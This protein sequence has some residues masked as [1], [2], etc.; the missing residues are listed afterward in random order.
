[1]VIRLPSRQLPVLYV[2]D[3]AVVG[4]SLAGIAAAL[5]WQRAGFHTVLIEPRTYLGR[6]I[7]ATFRPWVTLDPSSRLW[8]GLLERMGMTPQAAEIALPIDA[9]KRTLEDLLLEAGVALLYASLPVTVLGGTQ[10]I[11]GVVIANKSGR[12]VVAA[13]TV[14]D[15][16]ETA[17][18]ARL[19]GGA[20]APLPAAAPYE[21]TLEFDRVAPLAGDVLCVPADLGPVGD[22]VTLHH[23]YRGAEHLFVTFALDLPAADGPACAMRREILARERSL[24][25]AAHLIGAVPA[26]HD[27]VL[28]FASFEL[29]G[30]HTGRLDG[31]S[32]DPF[33]GPLP[34]LW[35]LN[36]AA[37]VPDPAA[38]RDPARAAA[39]GEL[40]ATRIVPRRLPGERADA[41]RPLPSDPAPLEIS[42]LAGSPPGWP[43]A[44]R[45]VPAQEVPVWDQVEVLVVGGGTSGATAAS[46]AA[47]EGARTML[48]EM[49]PGLGGTGT[50]GG[51]HSYWYGRHVGFSARVQALTDAVHQSLGHTKSTWNIEAKMFAL[52]QDA[53]RAGVCL[54]WEAIA[55]AAVKE[56]QRVRG[57][58]AA[59]RWGPVA[60]LGEVVIDATG[61]GDVAAF[62]G[63]DFVYGAE[64]DHTTMWYS[65]AQFSTPGRTRN[66]FTSSVD[67]GNILDYTRAILAGRRRG[68]DIHDHGVYP[69]PRESRHI[70]GEVVLTHTDQLRM[71][72]WRDV[73]NV[74]YSNHDVKGP[75]T[76]PWVRMGLIPPNLEIEVPYL[77]LIP[78]SLDGLIVTGKAI[79]ATHDAL[80]AIR[81]QADLENLGGVAALAALQALRRGVAP[82]DLDVATLQQRLVKED[83]LTP[84]ILACCV[85]LPVYRDE[86]LSDL[87]AAIDGSQPLWAYSDMEMGEI[88]QG[89]LPL[90]E[91][92]CAG[93]RIVPYLAEALAGARG[94]RRI[95]LAQALAFYGSPAA[96]PVLIEEIMARLQGD[97]LPV[98]DN[99]IRHANYPP[100][101]GAMPDVVYLLYSLGMTRDPRSLPV[102]A[103]VVELLEPSEDDLR[104]RRAGTFYYVEAIC[105]GMEQLADPAAVPILRRLHTFPPL[106]DQVCRSG[107]QAD[108]FLERQALLELCI[109]RA[110]ARCGDEEGLRTLTAYL[111]DARSLLARSAQAH[112]AA[113]KRNPQPRVSLLTG[114]KAEEQTREQLLG[115]FHR[116][117]LARWFFTPEIQIEEGSISHSHP[118]LTLNTRYLD[119]EDLLL[120]DYVHEQLHWFSK[121]GTGRVTTAMRELEDLYPNQPVSFP[122]GSGDRFGTYLH[123]V[124]C[125]LEYAALI[126]LLG[127]ERARGAVARRHVYSGIY[128]TVVA[129]YD[130][131]GAVIARHHA[132][133][134]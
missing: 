26:F 114:S 101:Q 45:A 82:R 62:A 98:R 72:H 71:R 84:E 124:I 73:V 17:L 131:I 2:A 36:E 83:I 97:A 27:A 113:I 78:R 119:D 81:M 53:E 117:D 54:L 35:C 65:L 121:D 80:A 21:R 125:Y 75:S 43:S 60:I 108:Y 7:T 95:H 41:V 4:G 3:V 64:C 29:S 74:H 102:Y 16:T 22:R 49:N 132:L 9:L 39:L 51:V 47:R 116:Y 48:L 66:N 67:V 19:A 134:G 42:E 128:A 46:T 112:L 129:E 79:S 38:F 111:D 12:Q 85:E 15:A 8:D 109:A 115:L 70:L 69:A 59:T 28:G 94:L 122:V 63:A 90:V 56:E 50:I 100:D 23:G 103:G 58:V 104:N 99:Q 86:D 31:P 55:F 89:R 61:D 20:L 110:Q 37:R 52:L 88:F 96:V 25:L 127:E 87:V 33:I 14:V 57:V 130:R 44:R 107:F 76:S 6:E 93:E 1:M 24:A 123:L 13:P 40:A 118:V 77:A 30:P 68:N 10:G 133:P 106:C 34:G 91:V 92:C 126:D 32:D 105:W 120:A 11:A 5:T 18:V